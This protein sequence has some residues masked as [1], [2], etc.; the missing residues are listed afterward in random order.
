MDVKCS[1][2][3]ELKINFSFLRY[4]RSLLIMRILYQK[5]EPDGSPAFFINI[6]KL[7]F[8]DFIDSMSKFSEQGSIIEEE[9]SALFR[10]SEKHMSMVNIENLSGNFLSPDLRIF[11]ATS[12]TEPRFTSKRDGV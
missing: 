8:K 2:L 12:G 5:D 6:V 10:D 7:V 3:M 11:K 4:L 9:H 1:I